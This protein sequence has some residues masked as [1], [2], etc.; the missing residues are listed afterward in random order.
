M[1]SQQPTPLP[2]PGD[3]LTALVGSGTPA[4][5]EDPNVVPITDTVIV[6]DDEA[7]ESTDPEAVA[8]EKDE[9]QSDGPA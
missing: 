7:D 8:P 9:P 6:P 4:P 3:E 2:K 1:G 5:E